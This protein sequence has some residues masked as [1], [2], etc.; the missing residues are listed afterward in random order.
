MQTTTPTP[1]ARHAPAIHPD[2]VSIPWAYALLTSPTTSVFTGRDIQQSKPGPG[3]EDSLTAVTLQTS[4][5]IRALASVRVGS[6][7]VTCLLVSL[8]TGMNGHGGILHGG[9]VSTLLDMATGSAVVA[10][11]FTAYLN[12]TFRKPVPTPSVVLCRGWLVRRE[13]RKLFIRGT[14]EDG[15]GG[16]YA[17]ADSLFVEVREKAKL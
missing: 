7:D 12:V 8:G 10:L 17:E 2:F 14:V 16:V 3:R 6:S 15:E 9:I 5:T 13:G 1:P 11:A 4:E